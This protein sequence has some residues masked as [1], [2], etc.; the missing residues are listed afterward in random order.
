MSN[1][2]NQFKHPIDYLLLEAAS[3]FLL[4]ETG[5]KVILEQTGNSTSLW[6]NQTKN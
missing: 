3:S 5:D 4:Q 2:N 1:W 6:T